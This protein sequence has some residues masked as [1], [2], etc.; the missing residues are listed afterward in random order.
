MDSPVEEDNTLVKDEVD[1]SKLLHHLETNT[2]ESTAKVR[3]G[4]EDVA[5]KAV[6]PA[7]KVR[8][9]RYYKQ[10]VVVVCNNFC[11]L[12]LDVL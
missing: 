2:V 10:L 8:C 5:M 9:L 3:A 11:K 4:I 7:S 1:S 6:G 12:V